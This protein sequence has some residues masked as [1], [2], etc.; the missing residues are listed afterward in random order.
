M[1][2]CHPKGR[3][4]LNGLGRLLRPEVALV[5]N[6]SPQHEGISGRRGIVLHVLILGGRLVLSRQSHSTD[7]LPPE[8]ES[9]I[10]IR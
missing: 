6:W 4:D 5:H 7:A 10:H 2:F 8:K 1:V 9:L 3:R